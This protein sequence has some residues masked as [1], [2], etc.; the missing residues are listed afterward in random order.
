MLPWYATTA[1]NMMG[2]VSPD[3]LPSPKMA[4]VNTPPNAAGS[5]TF[6]VVSH[7]LAP[8][9]NDASRISFGIEDIDSSVVLIIT[10]NIKND[11]V[12]QPPINEYPIPKYTTIAA[13][14]NKPNTIDGVP[15]SMPIALLINLVYL[16]S[17]AYSDRYTPVNTPNGNAMANVPAISF[18]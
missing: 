15:L 17:L 6:E 11:S 18:P 10:G 1:V 16:L 4:P 12:I 3:A 7:L 13:M 2:A 9:A 8:I 14:P 5:T